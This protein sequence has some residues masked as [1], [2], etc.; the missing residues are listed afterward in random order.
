[1]LPD[2]TITIKGNKFLETT[3]VF[4][5]KLPW[6]VLFKKYAQLRKFIA[7]INPMA[8]FTNNH[9]INE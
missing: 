4:A 8:Y 9:I 3:F 1:M 2:F 6:L 7:G 5:K